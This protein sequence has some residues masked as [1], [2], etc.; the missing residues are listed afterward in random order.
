MSYQHQTKQVKV[1]LNLFQ[2]LFKE[3]MPKPRQTSERAGSSA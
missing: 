1:T 3:E 2:S